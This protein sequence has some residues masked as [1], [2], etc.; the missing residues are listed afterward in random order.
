M[1]LISMWRSRQLRLTSRSMRPVLL[2]FWWL[3][4]LVR[5]VS[6]DLLDPLGTRVLSD[7]RVWLG[8]RVLLALPV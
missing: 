4:R 6:L 3:D 1:I 2:H 7:H 5:R 8:L